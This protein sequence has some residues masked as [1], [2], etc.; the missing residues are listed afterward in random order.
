MSGEYTYEGYI[1][2]F[3]I[4]FPS[5]TGGGSDPGPDDPTGPDPPTLELPSVSVAFDRDVVIFEDGYENSPGVFVSRCSTRT[6]L[7]VTASGGDTGGVL[8]LSIDGGLQ[9]CPEQSGMPGYVAPNQTI[10][11]DA[12]YEGVSASP[13]QNGAYATVTADSGIPGIDPSSDTAN[14]TVVE[15]KLRPKLLANNCQYRH[16]VGVCESVDCLHQPSS[17]SINWNSTGDGMIIEEDGATVFVANV[18]GNSAQLSVANGDTPYH[19]NLT[20]IEP[21][22]LLCSNEITVVSNSVPQGATGG[23]GMKL[24]LYVLPLTVSFA[25][26]A[27]E[28]VPCLTGTHSGYFSNP[29]FS[30]RW[31]HTYAMGAGRWRNV[32]LGNYYGQ[33]TST[34]GDWP[35]PWSWGIMTWDIPIGWTYANPDEGDPQEK[36]F[37]V[38]YLSTWTLEAD[39]SMSKSKH[40]HTVS[41]TT[42]DV[43]RLDGVIVNGN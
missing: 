19:S 6:K 38:Q 10:E 2:R 18:T 35:A 1:E 21:S 32:N 16:I 20:I 7:T 9:I 12:Y 29:I 23:I 27:V 26:I 39:G 30:G 34:S 8:A 5:D 3:G 13:S 37:P 40:G 24:H 41:R 25:N 22:G 42:N 17:F 36:N 43:I 33:D 28:E 14:A 11:W 31:S 15:V 4:S